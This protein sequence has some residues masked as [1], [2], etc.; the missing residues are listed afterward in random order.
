MLRPQSLGCWMRDMEDQPNPVR[1]R[2]RSDR[3][4]GPQPA[5]RSFLTCAWRPT[6]E[7]AAPP[8]EA[9]RGAWRQQKA[10]P[11]P[12]TV[13]APTPPPAGTSD[14]APG[15][16]PRPSLFAPPPTGEDP[17]CCLLRRAESPPFL[18]RPQP[19][20]NP[21]RV[22]HGLGRVSLSPEWLE[23]PPALCRAAG[24]GARRL[25]GSRR[26]DVGLTSSAAGLP[27]SVA[28]CS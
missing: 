14:S 13:T 3:T 21:L 7:L 24:D 16:E 17:G 10:P 15:N 6:S 8:G 9:L 1:P 28:G 12:R 26:G 25:S 11:I 5:S 27:R 18:L 4:K 22:L 19:L 23:R 20:P 2:S